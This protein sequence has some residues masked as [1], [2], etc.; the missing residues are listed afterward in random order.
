M[1]TDRFA[2]YGVRGLKNIILLTG[3][4]GCGKT[5]L[6]VNL[7]LDLR[8]AGEPVTIIDLDVVNP[9]FRTAD[10]SGLLEEKGI[11][12]ILP[13]YANSLVDVPALPREVSA[14]LTGEGRVIADVGGD[15][16]GASVIGRY[17]G[18][19]EK[20]GGADLL[21]LFSIYRPGTGTPADV[22]KHIESIEAVSRQRVSYLVNSS[23][24]GTDTVFEDVQRSFE[25]SRE[26]EALSGIPLLMTVALGEFA[27]R[28]EGAYAVKRYVRLPWEPREV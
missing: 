26:L 1:Y 24:L 3:H 16:A 18:D 11:R 23:N 10:F 2:E 6:A 7:A 27:G 19:I 17:S 15:D 13:G 25:F 22:R 12:A 21:Y 14:A 9:Y 5:N 20:A 28:I 4:Y 8:M